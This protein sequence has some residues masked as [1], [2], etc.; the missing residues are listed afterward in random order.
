[1]RDWKDGELVYVHDLLESCGN[2]NVPKTAIVS[3]LTTQY[4]SALND[5]KLDIAKGLSAATICW[6]AGNYGDA[7]RILREMVHDV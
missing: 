3:Y 4:V 5:H 7:K 1:M 2:A 6:K